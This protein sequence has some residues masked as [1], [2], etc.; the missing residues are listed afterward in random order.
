MTVKL[1]STLP[2]NKANGLD[3]ITADLIRNP[4][5]FKVVMAIVDCK[6]LTTDVD[7]GEVVP[8]ARIRRIEAVLRSDMGS[9]RL[10]MERATEA[11]TGQV[12]LPME[13]AEE[14]RAAFEKSF[15]DGD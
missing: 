12:A 2:N 5:R 10:L 11:R 15:S 3:A 8:T 14:M 1:A 7:T 13:F 4:E 6:S 9:A